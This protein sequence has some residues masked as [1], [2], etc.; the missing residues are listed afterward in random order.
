[1]WLLYVYVM[2]TLAMGISA[3][4]KG[5]IYAGIAGIVGPT[6]CSFGVV[7]LKA[8][9]M[10]GTQ[11]QKVGGLVAAIACVGIGLGIVYHSG[12]W[13]RIFSYELTGVAWCTIGLVVG[14]VTTK[15]EHAA[16]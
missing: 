10:V 7:G 6:L 14:Y 8:S 13:V 4:F 11:S 12:Y 16:A 9:L 15:R 1:M 5:S 2:G 3:L